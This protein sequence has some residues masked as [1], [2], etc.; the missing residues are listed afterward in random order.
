MEQADGYSALAPD[1]IHNFEW[2]IRGM[3]CPDCAMKATKA[4]SRLPGIDS[5]KIS[6]TEGT[7]R[8]GLDVSRGRISK[9]SSVLESL[10]H[11]P[12]VG[13]T[14]VVGITPRE[15]ASRIGK[16]RKGL[17][18]ELLGVP[19][20]LGIRMDDGKI[21]IQSLWIREEG[22]RSVAESMITAILGDDALYAPSTTKRLRD[23]QIKLITS[24][25]TIPMILAIL[26][27][28]SSGLPSIFSSIIGFVGVSMAGFKMFQEGMASIQNRILG[29]QV[30][31]SLAVLG[32][33]ILGEWAEAL[34]VVGL[35]ALASH[36]EERAIIR[37]RESMQG[38][39][40]RMP[41]GA[42]LVSP[43]NGQLSGVRSLNVIQRSLTVAPSC[44]QLDDCQDGDMTP[45]EA[46]GAGDLIEV[47]SGEIVPVDGTVTEGS[48]SLNRAPLTGEPV[49]VSISKGDLVEAGLTLVRGPVV[50]RAVAS[51]DE[52]RLSGLVDLVREYKDKPTRTQSS[53][54]TFTKYWVPL[55]L[56]LAPF[57]AFLVHGRSEE[58]IM[59]TAL[60]W[61]VS[62]PC[63]LL[64][65]APIPHAAALTSASSSGLIARG[66]DVLEAAAGV[67]LALL[68]KTGTLTSGHPVLTGI[69]VSDDESEDN[70]LRMA[71]GLEMRSNHPYAKSI[72]GVTE[73]R[74]IKPLQISDIADGDAGVTGSLRGQKLM[75]GRV[76]WLMSEGVEIPEE[77][78]ASLAE[79][80]KSGFGASVLS[81]EGRAIASFGFSHDDTREGV[82]EM[83]DSLTKSGVTIEILSGDEQSSV[84]AFASRFG[85]PPSSC[86]GGVDPEGKAAWV[87]EKSKAGK[88]LMAGDGFNDAGAL[89]AADVGIAVGSGD[90]VNLDA[91][92]VLIPGEDPRAL[93]RL[94]TLSRRTRS[95]VLANIAISIGVTLILVSA[96]LLGAEINL[97]VG[98][99]LHEASALLII[100]NGMWVTGTG[101]QRLT[102][103]FD[104]A[105]DIG[106]DIVDSFGA[107]I[108]RDGSETLR[109]LDK[110]NT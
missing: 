15:A 72:L 59:T 36:L 22:L 93:S 102:T 80:R 33:V 44:V 51:G 66:G 32:A 61:V 84:E 57:L 40:D 79:Y 35:E 109:P 41:R 82:A 49:P 87:S 5:C 43:S 110:S 68:D 24:V 108:G 88:T 37:A 73:S 39:L 14:Q 6:V 92:D 17:R 106:S 7:A 2:G 105:R 99:A 4:V 55:V 12:D 58:M 10:G 21:E 16:D 47:R 100:L 83:L 26:I 103:L 62:C 67:S 42:R 65:A 23:D 3:D 13:W 18:N 8:I 19:G 69:S 98:I 76:D 30:L 101:T 81:I 46:I 63:S 107:L 11:S 90:Q 54:E 97:A 96:V 91:A 94:I 9:S 25:L 104:L 45:V 78:D 27:V 50:I 71:A 28:E 38:G 70:V 95:V 48:G 85:I 89:A 31:T 52:T 60:L 74:S 29:F 1:G 34:M 77:L 75:L 56:V 53:I 64:L 86:R 20:V